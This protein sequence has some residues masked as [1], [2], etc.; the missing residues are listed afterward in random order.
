MLEFHLF[1][2]QLTLLFLRT[3]MITAKRLEQKE[4]RW[5]MLVQN[6]QLGLIILGTDVP[7]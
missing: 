4:V 1:F 7:T 3:V 2:Y 6:V 5:D